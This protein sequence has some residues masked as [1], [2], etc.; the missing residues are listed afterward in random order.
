MQCTTTH[1]RLPYTHSGVSSV[2]FLHVESSQ[3]TQKWLAE[4]LH[5]S[6]SAMLLELEVR[7]V[8]SG[9]T[10][11]AAETEATE[12]AIRAVRAK[13]VMETATGGDG[14]GDDAGG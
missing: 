13:V 11:T 9:G 5:D 6:V 8:A 2:P 10:L 4:S 14:D 1:K 12:A 3:A 7:E